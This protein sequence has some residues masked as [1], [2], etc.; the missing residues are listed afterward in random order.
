MVVRG[1]VDRRDD[2]PRLMAMDLSLPDLPT[3]T[4]RN[5]HSLTR[6]RQPVHAAPGSVPGSSDEPRHAPRPTTPG[7]APQPAAATVR[8]VR[9]TGS[10]GRPTRPGPSG[11][12]RWSRCRQAWAAASAT[13]TRPRRTPP[14]VA[15]ATSGALGWRPWWPLLGV[16]LACV[17]S[18]VAPWLPVQVS[19]GESSTP[20]RRASSAPA[21]RAGS[22][23]MPSVPGSCW[24]SW[25]GSAAPVP[26]RLTV[27][28]AHR[29]AGAPGR[30]GLRIGH[31]IGRGA[32]AESGTAD[33]GL[34]VPAGPAGRDA[35]DDIAFWRHASRT[36]AVTCSTWRVAGGRDVPADGRLR[37]RARPSVRAAGATT[38]SRRPRPASS[39]PDSV[40]R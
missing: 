20:S 35:A 12:D 21:R 28:A 11:V 36:S 33:G 14:S 16:P 39:R 31:T 24:R 22:C 30:P 38:G 6:C 17:W 8:P 29:C 7:P 13:R 4:G 40:G 3:S 27:G 1:R 18:S 15:S 9:P 37:G 2:Q 19:G 26:E 32:L 5:G 34:V 23:V 25:C 10:T